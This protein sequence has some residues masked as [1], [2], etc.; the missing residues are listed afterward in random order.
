MAAEQGH[1]MAQL[2]LGVRYY[3]GEG[4]PK[5]NIQAYAWTNIGLAQIGDEETR[6]LLEPIVKDMTASAIEKEQ[7]LSRQY[8]EA[9]S[10]NR[11]S[12]E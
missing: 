10:P 11:N 4:V 9:Y 5:D 1:A 6:Q 12:S 7:N 2:N 3:I 8:W